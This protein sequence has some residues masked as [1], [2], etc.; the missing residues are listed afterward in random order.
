MSEDEYNHLKAVEIHM[1]TMRERIAVLEERIARS[2]QPDEPIAMLTA[3]LEKARTTLA[4]MKSYW[5]KLKS[6][7]A[8]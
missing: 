2:E 6:D 4:A 7:G 3:T 5:Q 1:R 8:N